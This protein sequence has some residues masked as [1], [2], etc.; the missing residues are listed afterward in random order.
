[1]K[2]LVIY[3]S[4]TGFTEKYAKWIAKE[5]S[6]DI[7][8][9]RVINI[10]IFKDY[11][12]IIYGGSLH[13]VGIE[14]IKL[15]KDNLDNLKEKNIIVFTVGAT[16]SREETVQEI[17]RNNFNREQLGQIRFFYLRGGFNYNKLPFIDK[18]LM[19]LLQL[20][21][22]MKKNLTLDEKGMLNA[23][24]KPVDFTRRENIEDIISYIR[25]LK[26]E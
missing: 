26:I 8:S 23:Y 24:N 9:Y 16:P 19:K 21:L 6:A 11:D 20:K 4:K 17:K 25:S 3:K 5:I 2:C 13:A 14:G 1:M 7:Y 12:V 22:K 15:I 10:E 18:V